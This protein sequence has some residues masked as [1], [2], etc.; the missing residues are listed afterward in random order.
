MENSS[1][2]EDHVQIMT[3][4]TLLI[5]TA[6]FAQC[7]QQP[8]AAG[9]GIIP[10][11]QTKESRPTEGVE[12]GLWSLE[13]GAWVPVLTITFEQGDLQISEPQCPPLYNRNHNRTHLIGLS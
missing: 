9:T 11:L 5:N 12:D 8:H 2:W 3:I 13:P 4:V 6:P 7:P 1:V 10:I